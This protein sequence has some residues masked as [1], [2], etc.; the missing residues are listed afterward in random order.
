MKLRFLTALFLLALPMM[1]Q[2]PPPNPA[3]VS[4]GHDVLRAKDV[5]AANKFWQ[6]LGGQPVQFAGRL[7]LIKFPGVLLLTVGG[8]QGRGRGTPAPAPPA[9]L[10]GSEG[11]SLD[12]IGF[13]VKDLK[14]SLARW[15]EAGI[16]PLPGGSRTQV[17]LLSPDKIKVRITE[18][19]ALA[20]PIVADTI[21]MVVPNVAEAQ[22]WY[23]R[24]LGAEMVKRG[25]E[26]VANIPGSSIVFEQAKGPVA[27][28]K[29]RAF[30][31]IG[32]EVVGLEAFSKKLEDA[33]I[34]FDNPYRKSE[35][36]NAA[37]AVFQDPYGTLIELSEGLSAVK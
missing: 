37:F 23:A 8:A 32:L 10:A 13:S 12:W 33:G 16:Q 21:K 15:A 25:G 3:G 9:E 19:P 24:Y 2:L 7:N 11:S 5:D 6:A 14:G 27:P 35:P 1:A 34:R 4:A 20:A 28:T 36:M 17:Y 18:D 26:M 22:A 30:D 31:R 29:G